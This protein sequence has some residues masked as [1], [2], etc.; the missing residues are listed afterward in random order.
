ME[1]NINGKIK[2][3]DKREKEKIYLSNEEE[4]MELYG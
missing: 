2:F 1:L 4:E 3:L